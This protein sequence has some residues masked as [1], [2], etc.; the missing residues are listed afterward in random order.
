MAKRIIQNGKYNVAECPEC[1]C[2]FAFDSTDLEDNGTVMC[3]QCDTEIVPNI[4]PGN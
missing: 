3:P 1:N 4:R 2:I